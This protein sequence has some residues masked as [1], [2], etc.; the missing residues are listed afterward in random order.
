MSEVPAW[1]TA[2]RF[3][4]SREEQLLTNRKRAACQRG[5]RNSGR[6]RRAM[7][8][9]RRR[10]EGGWF[11]RQ[12]TREQFD[13]LYAGMCEREGIPDD[14][15]GRN[16]AYT[17]YRVEAAAWR[18]K[19]QDFE[20][21][22]GQR[23]VA[24]NSRG[25]ERQ[26]RTVQRTRKRLE[27]MGLL[28]Y[29]HIRRCGARAGHRDSL[30]VHFMVNAQARTCANDTLRTQRRSRDSVPADSS[31]ETTLIAPAAR[32]GAALRPRKRQ[33]AAPPVSEREESEPL[34]SFEQARLRLREAAARQRA[35]LER[36]P[37]P[38][39]HGGSDGR[40]I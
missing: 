23:T 21:T 27:A 35:I 38:S 17:L 40:R 6:S 33:A 9:D 34:L 5:G 18:A 16:T 29:S 32:A 1:V 22:N 19:G 24:L 3:A 12:V 11:V 36:G 31:P 26:R 14:P 10:A 25:R 39:R 2:G 20:T 28:R 13:A 7:A 30:R 4:D 37:V 15:R 8:A